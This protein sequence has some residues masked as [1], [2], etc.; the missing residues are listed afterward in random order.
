M[1]ILVPCFNL[2][3]KT[4]ELLCVPANLLLLT[5][6]IFKGLFWMILSKLKTVFHSMYVYALKWTELEIAKVLQ[7]S[8]HLFF[9]TINLN[10]HENHF[11]CIKSM[12]LHAGPYVIQIFIV[13]NIFVLARAHCTLDRSGRVK[14]C[15]ITAFITTPYYYNI[16]P[17]IRLLCCTAFQVIL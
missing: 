17:E 16:I 11:S 4:K 5:L 8:R 15:A 12:Q 7:R 3:C 14:S 1:F 10:V 2:E 9:P 13:A 6:A